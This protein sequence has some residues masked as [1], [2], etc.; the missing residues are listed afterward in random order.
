M[1]AKEERELASSVAFVLGF[2]VSIALGYWGWSRVHG[3]F[4]DAAETAHFF[5]RAYLTLQLFVLHPQDLPDAVPWQL[6]AARFMAPAVL[7]LATVTLITTKFRQRFRHMWFRRFPGHTIICGAGVHGT[8]LA[9]N[10]THAGERVVLVDIDERAPGMRGPER[11]HEYRLVADTVRKDTLVSAGARRAGRLIAV[12]GDDVVNS[13]IASTVRSLAEKQ[14]V[15]PHLRVLVQAEDAALARFLEDWDIRDGERGDAALAASSAAGSARAPLPRIEVFG[16][17]AIAADA[18]FGDGA[19]TVTEAEGDGTAVLSDLESGRESHLLLAGDHPLLEAIVVASLR[20]G[21]ARRLRD[22]SAAPVAVT[23]ALRITLVG[24]EAESRLAAIRQRWRPEPTVVDLRAMDVDL[25]D[26]SS[27]LTS[28]WLR[29]WR[30]AAHAFVACEDELASI[31]LAIALSRALGENVELTRVRTQPRNELDEQLHTHTFGNAHLSTISVHSI[32]D[33][34]WGYET[35][36][37]DDVEAPKRLAAALRAEGVKG[38]DA[39]EATEHI[40]AQRWLGVRSDL[41]PRIT[42]ASAPLVGGLLRS[43]SNGSHVTVSTSALVGAGLTVDLDSRANLGRAAEQLASENSDGAFAAWCEYARRT[44][45]EPTA[46]AELLALAR[47]MTEVGA[48]LRLKATALGLG[49]ALGGLESDAAAVDRIRSRA[50]PRIA[51]FAGG[52]ASMSEETKR[53]TA[54]L[55]ERALYRYDGLILTGG[56]DVGLCGVVRSTASANGV[57]VLGYA[58]A[59]RGLAGARLRSTREGEFSEA[60]PVAMWTDILA[61]GRASADVRVVAF[62]GGRITTT[63]IILARALGATVAWLDP[64]E[65]LPD[66]LDDTLPLGAEGVI[67]LPTDPMTLRAFLT[68]P[69]ADLDPALRENAARDLHNLYREEHRKHKRADDQALAPWEHLSPALQRSNLAAVDDIPNKLHVIGKCLLEGGTRLALDDDDVEL[70]AEVEHG[71]FNYERLGAGWELG[72]DRRLIQL[73]SPYLTPWSELEE[74]VKQWDRDAVRAIDNVL[75]KAG[76]G[77]AAE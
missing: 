76:W 15:K 45:D 52:A 20:R 64:C 72:R 5:G 28:R 11:G 74:H 21:R 33:L 34:A 42:P 51:I 36:R 38:N 32:A 27:I 44:P 61:A 77:V 24:A 29:E 25:R 9:Q 49:E 67:E 8:R 56:N 12:T 16:A 66:A 30:T 10:L 22:A 53:A 58:P 35:K 57:P 31:A 43:A 1:P 13:Q 39:E 50:S 17:N 3:A 55:L 73:I 40:L 48:P 37:I 41:A 46:A 68:W 65:E 6:Q 14:G 19:M 69:N 63:E 7:A 26:E 23:P 62:P 75:R 54:K 2:A 70:L 4:T 47:T 71:R 60:E 18:L 59:D